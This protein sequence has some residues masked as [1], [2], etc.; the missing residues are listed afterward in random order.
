MSDEKYTV[1]QVKSAFKAGFIEASKWPSVCTQDADS[2][3]VDDAALAYAATLSQQA[4]RVDDETQQYKLK[5]MANNYGD[6]PHSWDK[7]DREVCEKAAL[8]IETLRADLSAQP[9][10]ERQG[11]GLSWALQQGG[12]LADWCNVAGDAL[13]ALMV[14]YE[15]RVRSDCGPDDLANGPWRCEEF[16]QAEQALRGKPVPIVEFTHPA[17]PVGVPDGWVLVQRA[18]VAEAVQVLRNVDAQLRATG[19]PSARIEWAINALSPLAAA[20]EVS[21][22]GGDHG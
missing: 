7:L 19:Q 2:P 22:K 14:A 16:V 9:A 21:A 8:E 5:A 3:A 20:P 11:D 15:R 13:R 10:P 12:V 18:M 4:G 6:G 1:E 17:A